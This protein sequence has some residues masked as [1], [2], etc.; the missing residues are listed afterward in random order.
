[1]KSIVRTVGLFVVFS[2][3]GCGSQGGSTAPE[4][5]IPQP[6]RVIV[7]GAG[8]AG[9]T[10]ARTLHDA[11]VEV[12]VLEA[13]DRIGGR[14]QTLNVGGAR[15][16]V[17]AAWLHGVN[18]NPLADFAD[19][20]GLA[21]HKHDTETNY[22][23]ID[24]ATGVVDDNTVAAAEAEVDAFWDALPDLQRQLGAQASVSDALAHFLDTLSE[25]DEVE[26]LVDF[27]IG[28][29][30]LDIELSGPGERTSLRWFDAEEEFS[31]GDYLPANGYAAFIETLA[32]GLDI[33]TAQPVR[34][35]RHD[36][37][38]VTVTTPKGV[39]TGTHV[40]VTVSLGV[41]KR[42]AIQF[43]PALPA[44]KQQAIARLEMG[45][46][47]K[48][49]L[50][51][52][53]AFWQDE[54]DFS[55]L[56]WVAPDTASRRG[57]FP[58]FFNLTEQTGKPTLVALYGGRYSRAIQGKQSDA[59]IISGALRALEDALDRPIPSPVSTHVTHWTTDPWFGG[60][61]SYLPVGA[62]PDDMEALAAPIDGRVLFAGEATIA[63][64]Y[65]T[66]HGAMLS[67]LREAERLG[68][69]NPHR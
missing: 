37:D 34:A 12:I 33:R 43:S 22:L 13:Q 1:M 60:S 64:H 40:I 67:G 25:S 53:R 7:V 68:V 32:D 4:P 17:G 50:R 11:G 28:Q 29:G 58:E 51:F 59:Q 62:S 26:R 45:N 56:G 31:G 47:E 42:G 19:A 41:L 65:Q 3:A 63:D 10:A 24:A 14:M 21:Y 39:L 48:V 6:G 36:A 57:E 9:L 8:M 18:G 49:V 5:V 69:R 35:I 46:L 16:D 55:V 20:H 54:E 2:I 30:A 66:V 61:Y 27:F 15:V 52:D 23:T 44:R 38:G